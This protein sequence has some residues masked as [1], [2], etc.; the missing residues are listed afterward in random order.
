MNGRSH[1]PGHSDQDV[2]V[3]GGTWGTVRRI[4]FDAVQ[5]RLNE[6]MKV[7]PQ[8]EI[9]T[10]EALLGVMFWAAQPWGARIKAGL[11]ISYIASKEVLPLRRLRIEGR[12]SLYYRLL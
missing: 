12:T 3:M 11:C 2:F 9:C 1:L 8:G 10:A 5:N 6:R 7:L 4:F